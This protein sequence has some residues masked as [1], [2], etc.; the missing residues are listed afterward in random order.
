MTL[1]TALAG[2]LGAAEALR[3]ASRWSETAFSVDTFHE[4][5]ALLRV[6][7]PSAVADILLHNNYL[8]RLGTDVA[9][10][11]AGR[12]LAVLLDAIE[13]GNITDAFDR[14]GRMDALDQRYELV[15]EGMTEQFVDSLLYRPDFGR[16]YIASPWLNPTPKQLAKMKAAV[17]RL[18][19]LGQKVDISVVTR[20][21][22]AS[23]PGSVNGLSTFRAL[24]ARIF[25]NRRLHTKLYVR[26]P[27]VAGGLLMAIVGS[28]NFT[29]STHIE[30]G[31]KI[32]S[33]TRLIQQLIAYHFDLCT[34]SSEE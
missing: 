4:R 11:A 13:T 25:F 26:E 10:S 15:R 28:Q 1:V 7:N 29:R 12:R 32:T 17:D 33:D 2:V 21:P 3:E 24:G 6:E 8:S 18:R 23:P 9:I 20:P 27:S 22:D 30:L 16:I 14:L 5:L 19:S 31:I 34:H